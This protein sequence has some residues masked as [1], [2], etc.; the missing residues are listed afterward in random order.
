MGMGS[1]LRVPRYGLRVVF[2]AWV[3]S[4]NGIR[5]IALNISRPSTI[6]W[7]YGAG[8]ARRD[9][10]ERNGMA[11]NLRVPVFSVRDRYDN[12]KD[13]YQL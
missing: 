7:S 11:I 5:L 13:K 3:I 9:R 2:L 10:R 6:F 12:N 8:S 1:E 4:V